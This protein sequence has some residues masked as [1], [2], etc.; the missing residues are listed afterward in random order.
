MELTVRTHAA[1]TKHGGLAGCLRV[2]ASFSLLC[3][4][5]LAKTA[6]GGRQDTRLLA[7]VA[8]ACVSL[9]LSLTFTLEVFCIYL[10]E[11]STRT[12]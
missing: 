7:Q 6:E 9:S 3:E 2:L 12:L 8:C 1:L 10:E 11:E 4:N 5:T